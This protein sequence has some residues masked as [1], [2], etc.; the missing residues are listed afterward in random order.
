MISFNSDVTYESLTIL[1]F[2]EDLDPKEVDDVLGITSSKSFQKGDSFSKGT[3]YRKNGMWSLDLTGVGTYPC[4]DLKSFANKIP[5]Q[6]LPLTN[7]NGVTSG[8]LALWLKN[9]D[10]D[11]TLELSVDPEDMNLMNSLGVQLYVTIFP[12]AE[13]GES[14]SPNLADM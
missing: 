14:F 2:G 13:Q 11:T 8:R 10:R 7:I 4:D 9:N 12:T 1:L 3:K 5:G 6:C